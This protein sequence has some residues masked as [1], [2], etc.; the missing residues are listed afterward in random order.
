MKLRLRD[1]VVA[2]LAASLASC[3]GAGNASNTIPPATGSG[4][5]P[6]QSSILTRIVGVGDSLTAGYQADGFLG[7]TGF[8]DPYN[9]GVVPPG[10][11]NG[12]WADLNEQASN[13]S[14]DRSIG[15]M[16]DPAVSPLPLIKGPGLNNQLIPASLFPFE[17]QKSG[18]ACTDYHG[19]NQAGYLLSGL[20]RVRMNPHS[21]TIRNLG[22]PGITLHE[23]NVLHEP[24]TDTCQPL[25]GIPGLLS[26]V[27]ADES[28]SFW[29]VLGN[30]TKL[31]QNLTLVD[32]AASLHPTLATVWLGANDVLK[33]MGSGGL[34]VGGDRTPG[35]AESDLNETIG[36][37]KHAGARVVV[38]NLPNIVEAGYLQRVTI[39]ANKTECPLRTYAWCLLAFGLDSPS[40]A[41]SVTKQ[42]AKAYGLDTPQGCVPASVSR[43][44]GYLTLGA[45]VE[46][47]GYFSAYGSVPNL[48]CA[49]PMPG[50]KAVAGSGLG[51][52]YI[53]PEFAGKIQA[54]NNAMNEGIDAAASH[55]QVALVD[56]Q[57]IF[58]GLV[59]G[60]PSNQYFARAASI[61]PGVCCAIGYLY[62]ILS[63]DG[64]HPSN[65]GY[66]LITYYFIQELNRAYGA[67]IPQIDLHAAYAGTRC[68]N[69]KYCYPDPYAPPNDFSP[70]MRRRILSRT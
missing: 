57:A 63:F 70:A 52:N 66:A 27:V 43:P 61:E 20:S 51:G 12:W 54:L 15:E 13:E 39:P 9:G 37:L 60:D 24:Q 33:Y 26:M 56:I 49:N 25:P 53:T 55:N 35:E 3:G 62:G 17:L 34:F 42:L 40:L 47:I 31:G 2:L 68:R 5:Q 64:L 38:A 36:T 10:Q 7:E 11:E 41:R 69:R 32:A 65:S 22:I 30:F 67:H 1:M 46:V 44:C 14:L 19:F 59:S 8:K 45:V 4:V 18:D 23:A 6:Q 16:F 50:C 29:P 28:S 21:T 48:D 58:H